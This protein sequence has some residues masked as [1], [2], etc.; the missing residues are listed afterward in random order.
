SSSTSTRPWRWWIAWSGRKE[1]WHNLPS[2]GG[3]G[4]G[5]RPGFPRGRVTL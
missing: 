4:I 5:A 1:E 3:H 2:G